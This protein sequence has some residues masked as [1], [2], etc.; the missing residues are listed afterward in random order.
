M[1]WLGQQGPGYGWQPVADAAE[2]Q[3][4][5]NTGILVVAAHANPNPRRPG[6]IAVIRPS[7]KTAA[8]LAEQG[9]QETQAGSTNALSTTVA[10]GF[11]HHRGAWQPG[12][13]GTIRYYAHPV[14][15]P[16]VPPDGGRGGAENR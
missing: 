9:P 11:R 2:A 5:A 14:D 4:L 16:R 6:H 3:R 13:S 10:Y 8:E 1:A 7:L 15:W 12:G